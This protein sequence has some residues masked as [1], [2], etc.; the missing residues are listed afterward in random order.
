MQAH[1]HR[2]YISLGLLTIYIDIWE[3][4]GSIVPFKWYTGTPSACTTMLLVLT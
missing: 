2:Q 1:I 4:G 3:R